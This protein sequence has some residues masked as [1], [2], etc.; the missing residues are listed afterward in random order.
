MTKEDYSEVY[1]TTLNIRKDLFSINLTN[2]LKNLSGSATRHIYIKYR[3]CEFVLIK[4][5]DDEKDFVIRVDSGLNNTLPFKS[6]LY[7]D[8][9]APTGDYDPDSHNTSINHIDF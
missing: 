5:E 9:Y 7:N 3:K 8:I 1:Q 2:S 6:P 4:S